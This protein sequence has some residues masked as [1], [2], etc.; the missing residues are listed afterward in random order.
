MRITAPMTRPAPKNYVTES[1]SPN[2]KAASATITT[3]SQVPSNA[4]RSQASDSNNYRSPR[5][6]RAHLGRRRALP[7]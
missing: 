3:G 1:L 7:Y 5:G 6:T 4:A 2:N